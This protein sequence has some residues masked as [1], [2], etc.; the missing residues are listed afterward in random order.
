MGLPPIRVSVNLSPVQFRKP[1]L[2][3]SVYDALDDAGLEADG[4]ELEVTES[5]L[6]NDPAETA[7]ILGKLKSRGIHISIDDFGTGYSSLSYLKRFPINALKIDR[8]FITD[9]TTNP[10]DAAITTAIILMGH[11]LK[12]SVVAEGVETENQLAFLKVLQC[13]EVQ[14][15]LFSPPV[16]A[17]RAQEMLADQQFAKAAA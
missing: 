3:E 16:P 10:D 14:G 8:S 9:V 13:N 7:S 11:S 2:H 12:L 5:L 4:L 1:N 15:F 17:E 6:M